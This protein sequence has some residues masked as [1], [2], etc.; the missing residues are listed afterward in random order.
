MLAILMLLISHYKAHYSFNS[1]HGARQAVRLRDLSVFSPQQAHHENCRHRRI[2]GLLRMKIAPR[3]IDV[4]VSLLTSSRMT[5]GGST[6]ERMG[7]DVCRRVVPS[8]NCISY[9]PKGSVCL[10][11]PFRHSPRN[12]H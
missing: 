2:D 10:T 1:I 8:F 3:V 7:F 12:P 4:D 9:D 6:D 5:I 11:V